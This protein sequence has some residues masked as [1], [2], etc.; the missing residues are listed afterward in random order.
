MK[1]IF[2]KFKPAPRTIILTSVFMLA[3]FLVGM[4][5]FKA[6]ESE[7]TILVVPKSANAV[8]QQAQ[9]LDNL[10]QLPKT[11][12]FY[13]RLLKDNTTFQD[14]S[15]G[16]S[17]LIRKNSWNDMFSIKQVS[18]KG[19]MLSVSISINS[20]ADADIIVSKTARTLLDMTSFY[21]N[22]KDDVDLRIVD[23]PITK[24][25]VNRWPL[26]LL[27]S[28]LFGSLLTLAVEKI[29][30]LKKS[31]VANQEEISENKPFQNFNFFKKINQPMPIE[32]LENLY[33]HETKIF[34]NLFAKKKPALSEQ[35][36]EKLVEKTE[37]IEVAEPV[38]E[39]A[40]LQEIASRGV[41]PN[42]PEMPV[43]GAPKSFAPANLPIA[44]FA[45][46]NDL[47]NQEA[48]AEPEAE[49]IHEPTS[50]E[51]KNRLNQLLK[52]DL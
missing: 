50:D 3:F 9:I 7:M 49:K 2:Q 27:I 15:A 11:L 21:Y 41:Y 31:V 19:S 12:A 5:K 28:L 46:E 47:P 33:E 8:G 18:Q 36:A 17:P 26:L 10:I 52:G 16:E 40:H 4:Q 39:V 23:G 37:E 44:D 22:V 43:H 24:V 30:G 14:S 51:L 42:F 20:Q 6:Y 13:D 1:T 34:Q 32:A 38:A 29:L 45:I 25:V 35:P 48:E